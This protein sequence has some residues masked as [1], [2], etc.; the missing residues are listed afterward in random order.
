MEGMKSSVT[1]VLARLVQSLIT[2][3]QVVYLLALMI[4]AG[5]QAMAQGDPQPDVNIVGPTKDPADIRDEGLKQQNEPACAIRPGD[6]DCFI[7]FFNDYRT[8]DLPGHE[9]AWVGAAESCDA[10]NTWTSRIVPNHPTHPFPIDAKFAADPR[11]VHIPGMAIHGFIGGFRGQDRGVI[12]VQHWLEN[13]KEDFD[14]YEPGRESIVVDV[15]TEG[16][17][18]DKPEFL[19]VLTAGNPQPR[20]T[21]STVM[22][23]PALGTVTRDYPAG[24]LFA[25]YA[26]FTGSQGVKLLVKRS[27]NWGQSWPN[28]S[29]KLT[30]SQNLVSGISMTAKGGTIMAMWRQALDTNDSDALYFATTT[31]DSPGQNRNC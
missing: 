19:G 17:F 31:W 18:I 25:A 20:T 21:L 23:N 29:I 27:D 24:K 4:F 8:V 3:K 9:D 5:Q 1:D 12:V 14:R 30:E 11:V 16:R 28:Q 7:C 26:V 13:N 15:G 2:R 6:S 22:E 10:G